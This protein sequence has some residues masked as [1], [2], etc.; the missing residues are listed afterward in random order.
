MPRKIEYKCC[1]C[2][3]ELENKDTIRLCKQLYGL[4][5]RGG[6]ETVKKY[7]FCKECYKKFAGWIYKHR[8]E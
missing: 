7:D 1:I 3:N 5:H 6:H 4:T 8:E 2:H